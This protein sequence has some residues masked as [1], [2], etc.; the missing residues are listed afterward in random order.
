[1]K[2]VFFILFLGILSMPQS[3]FAQHQRNHPHNDNNWNTNGNHQRYE[4]LQ[5]PH[6]QTFPFLYYQQRPLVPFGYY[7]L[8]PNIYYV[9]PQ[10]VQAC[11]NVSVVVTAYNI[12]YQQQCRWGWR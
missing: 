9:Q 11:Y 5:Q 2:K 1:M 4:L 7:A 12:T 3:S 6:H 8:Q 10:L